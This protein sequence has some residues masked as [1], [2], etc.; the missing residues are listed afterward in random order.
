MDLIRYGYNGNLLTILL[1]S[2]GN[3]WWV[4]GEVCEPLGFRMASDA[5]R[6]LDDDEKA[7]HKLRTPGGFQ[8]VTI[9][10]ESGLYS[11]IFKSRK[12]EAKAFRRWVTHEVLPSIRKTGSYIDKDGTRSI[13]DGSFK[14]VVEALDYIQSSGLN[15]KKSK[16]YQDVQKGL[17]KREDDGRILS[18]TVENYIRV[19]KDSGRPKYGGDSFWIASYYTKVSRQQRDVLSILEASYKIARRL[20]H[21]KEDAISIAKAKVE[22]T[23]GIRL[24]EVYTLNSGKK[25]SGYSSGDREVEIDDGLIEDFIDD[26]CE[27]GDDYK[28]GLNVLYERFLDWFLQTAD[29][30]PPSREEFSRHLSTFVDRT[31]HAGTIFHGIKPSNIK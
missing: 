27:I 8:E 7:T 11:L 1:N 24:D 13:E 3:P 23:T 28:S 20:G 18:S 21:T 9:I 6:L 22:E 16:I 5:T 29:S 14:N 15:I 26:N 25:R 12:P 17:L 4:A 30:C 10:N 19:H 2:N 31:Q